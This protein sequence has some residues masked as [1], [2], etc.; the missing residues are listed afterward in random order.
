LAEQKRKRGE[1]ET[2][3]EWRKY[4]LDETGWDLN[5]RG[6][7]T[8]GWGPKWLSVPQRA[9]MNTAWGVYLGLPLSY[10][11]SYR[12]DVD[13]A[14]PMQGAANRVL[15]TQ[16]RGSF[17]IAFVPWQYITVLGGVTRGV[18]EVPIAEDQKRFKA[19]WMWTV[20][21]GGNLETIGA[22]IKSAFE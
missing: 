3:E 11:A 22:L 8:W 12:F 7:C 17:G 6:R 5:L 15:R 19:Q 10:E 2:D 21:I 18:A 20:G 1:K 14:D 9:V 16:T 13:G 4:V